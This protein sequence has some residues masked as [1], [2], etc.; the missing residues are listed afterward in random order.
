MKVHTVLTSE[1]S[2]VCIFSHTKKKTEDD[3]ENNRTFEILIY[4]AVFALH[5]EN[6]ELTRKRNGS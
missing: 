3:E 1:S 5:V 4:F 2:S 6:A